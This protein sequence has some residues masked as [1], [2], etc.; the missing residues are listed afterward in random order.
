MGQ[1]SIGVE[2]S[3]HFKTAMTGSLYGNAVAKMNLRG[4]EVKASGVGRYAIL[5]VMALWV[6]VCFAQQKAATE[7]L[8]T[9]PDLPEIIRRLTLA[10]LANHE[11]AHSYTVIRQYQL[12]NG[13]KQNDSSNVVAEISYFPPATKEY[14]IRT[15]NGSGS[16]ER[17]VRRV[18]E[19]EAE[20]AS[21]WRE[22][23]ITEEN[24]SFALLGHQDVDG[25][26][27][28]V[29]SIRP[30]RD[31]KDLIRGRAWVDAQSFNLRRIEGSPVKNPSW[32]VKH[33][34]LT[35]Q[36][37]QIMGM[38]LQTALTARAE[39]R[40]FGQRVLTAQD[41]Q[42]DTPEITAAAQDQKQQQ[43]KLPDG[44]ATSVVGVGVFV[45]P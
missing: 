2:R 26:D 34:D 33:V 39:I 17:V 8:R 1:R 42:Y 4:L 12:L 27:C 40:L 31:T 44:R 3:T 28:F 22:A 6:S 19:H 11:N 18:L 30:K 23:A 16:G 32:W 5:W 7:S 9:E 14:V 21:S 15:A 35:L 45:V 29:L 37:S 24:Y 43:T 10:Q 20:M 36:F 38:W 41:L 13:H 25:S